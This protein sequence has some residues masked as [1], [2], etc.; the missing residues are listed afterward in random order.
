MGITLFVK[1]SSVEGRKISA[2]VELSESV[3][4]LKDK[5]VAESGIPSDEQRLVYKGQVLKDERQLESYG[6]QNEHVLHLVRA[7]ATGAAAGPSGCYVC[8]P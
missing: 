6:F 2:T 5:L 7:R 3:R 8:S 4:D 1:Q